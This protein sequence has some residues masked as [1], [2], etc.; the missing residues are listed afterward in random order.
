MMESLKGEADLIIDTSGLSPHDL[1]DRV[2]QAFSSGPV[3]TS[4]QISVVSFGYKYGVPRDVDLMMDV[5]FLPNP[6]WVRELR[7]L[8]GTDEKVRAYVKR[9]EAYGPFMEKLTGL[10]D[11]TLPGYL[12]EGK[13]FLVIGV[14]CTGGRHRS[15][16][17]AEDLVEYFA[18]RDLKV[19]IEHRDLDRD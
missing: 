16:V 8:P 13:A 10:L 11:V 6:H 18:G 7:P 12:A 15:V 19:T 9:Q 4:V 17:V 3:R 1:R 5:R 2:R 14:G